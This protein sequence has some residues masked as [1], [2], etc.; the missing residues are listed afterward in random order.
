MPFIRFVLTTNVGLMTKKKIT[1]IFREKAIT[2]K[3]RNQYGEWEY[4]E[5]VIHQKRAVANLSLALR[6]AHFYIDG[7]IV[8]LILIPISILDA[9]Y[10]WV[11]W[12]FFPALTYFSYYILSEFYFQKTIAKKLTGSLVVNEYGEKPDFKI[13]CLRTLAR[14]VPFNPFSTFWT[15]DGRFWH[16]TWTKTFVISKEELYLIDRIRNGENPKKSDEGYW[17]EWHSWQI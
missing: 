5:R 11:I 12:D 14:I 10:P 3:E 6:A 15:D 13:I 16:D 17:D 7:L 2:R 4:V 9:Y 8:T 1:D